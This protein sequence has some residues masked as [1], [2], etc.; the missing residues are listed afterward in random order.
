MRYLFI[1]IIA[2]LSLF[3]DDF[4][5]AVEDYNKGGYIKALNTFYALA[6][7]GDPKAQ[8]NFGFIYAK[9]KGVQ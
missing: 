3:A 9:G 2:V 4:D 1:F 7:E 6:K 8:Y 5:Q